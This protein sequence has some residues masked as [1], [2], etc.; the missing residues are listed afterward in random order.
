[1]NN[2]KHGNNFTSPA[3]REAMCRNRTQK[4]PPRGSSRS[5]V[6][7]KRALVKNTYYSLRE[8]FEEFNIPC[9]EKTFGI[10]IVR[11]SVRNRDQIENINSIMKELLELFLIDEIGM[12]MEYAEKFRS[13]VLFLRPV[14]IE[15]TNKIHQ[16]FQESPFQFNRVVLGVEY[17]TTATT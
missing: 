1:M 10:G 4:M 16:V 17:P 12:P 3:R 11:I 6:L 13:L 14:D 9:V 8:I 7:I 15:S 2:S 5:R